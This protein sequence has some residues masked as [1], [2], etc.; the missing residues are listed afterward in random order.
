MSSSQNNEISKRV[1]KTPLKSIGNSLAKVSQDASVRSFQISSFSIKLNAKESFDFFSHEYI[2]DENTLPV[3]IQKRKLVKNKLFDEEI[4]DIGLSHIKK[5]KQMSGRVLESDDENNVIITTK[6]PEEISFL[7]DNE[8]V[9]EPKHR[10]RHLKRPVS[11]NEEPD[12][13]PNKRKKSKSKKMLTYNQ[14]YDEDESIAEEEEDGY[15][16]T[17][18]EENEEIETRKKIRTIKEDDQLNRK[19]KAALKSEQERKKRL[20]QIKLAQ[21]DLDEDEFFLDYD[22]KKKY[23]NLKVNKFITEKLKPHQRDGIKFMWNSYGTRYENLA[24][25]QK[26]KLGTGCLLA[27]CMGLG[28]T[29]QVIAFLH[30][31]LSNSEK[32]KCKKILILM[33]VNVISNWINEINKWNAKC[34]TKIQIHQIPTVTSN[35]I[36]A[37][38]EALKNWFENGGIF[39]IG[40]T[41]FAN[42]V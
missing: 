42:L 22:Q 34:E 27:H 4:N 6:E 10:K 23:S 36:P 32:T 33:P 25:V 30:T 5:K 29:L 16:L 17:D 11:D 40:Y 19:T 28:K 37:R 35:K 39:L 14:F 12:Q 2:E 15:E 3:N 38:L 41:M 1:F 26:N 24:M 18:N 7:S 31:L 20:E 9:V 8:Q 13:E 21:N